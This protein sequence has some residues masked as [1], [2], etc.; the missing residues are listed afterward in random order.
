M[1]Q[2]VKGKKLN[3]S[4]QHRQALFKNLVQELVWHEKIETTQI[5][6]KLI[7]SKFEKTLNK[8]KQASLHSRRQIVASLFDSKVADKICND[9]IL[10]YQ[11]KTS[12]YVQVMRIGKRRGDNTMMWKLTLKPAQVKEEDKEKVEKKS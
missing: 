6:A 10:R 2:Q 1:S 9:L 4:Y 3:R 12:G 8:A 7:I 5:K 11:D